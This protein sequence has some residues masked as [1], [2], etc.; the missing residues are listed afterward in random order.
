MENC[1]VAMSLLM[2]RIYYYP[3]ADRVMLYFGLL[4]TISTTLR[5]LLL[6][7]LYSDW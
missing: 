4:L 2:G 7:R 6:H 3:T 1:L 5:D